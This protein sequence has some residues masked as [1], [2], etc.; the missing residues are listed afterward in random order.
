M[1]F[2]PFLVRCAS[3][4][5]FVLNYTTAFPINSILTYG[6]KK[7]GRF[8]ISIKSQKIMDSLIL[9]ENDGYI[10]ESSK[11]LCSN[12]DKIIKDSGIKMKNHNS[13]MEFSG[14][15]NESGVYR[16][17]IV[18]CSQKQITM[19]I[20]CSFSNPDSLLDYRNRFLAPM[21]KLMAILYACIFG[22]WFSQSPLLRVFKYPLHTAFMLLP[23]L[24]SIVLYIWH[25]NWKILA[26]R[27]NIPPLIYFVS[28]AFDAVFFSSYLSALLFLCGGCNVYRI[29]FGIREHLDIILASL[30]QTIGIIVIPI[31]NNEKSLIIGFGLTIGGLVWYLSIGIMSMVKAKRIVALVSEKPP[32]M[33]KIIKSRKTVSITYLLSF[34]TLFIYVAMY[35][36]SMP[37]F[38]CALVMEI[39]CFSCIIIMFWFYTTDPSKTIIYNYKRSNFSPAL[40]TTPC[41]SDMVLLSRVQRK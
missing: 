15:V 3:S 19:N 20:N 16:L 2:L 25:T 41:G 23:L 4:Q 6:F 17:F 28:H 13:T 31:V 37:E 40:I 10:K 39:G 7:G 18:S 24:R 1:F 36:A 33:K 14:K 5:L 30:T 11:Y 8:N 38:D 22:Y 34:I 27:E 29:T 21:F 26:K 12:K 32:L 35:F 9:L